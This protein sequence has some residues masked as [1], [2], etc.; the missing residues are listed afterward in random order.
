[1]R[2]AKGREHPIQLILL[3]SFKTIH[4][5][6]KSLH[7]LTFHTSRSSTFLPHPLSILQAYNNSAVDLFCLTVLIVVPWCIPFFIVF[8]MRTAE[9][10]EHPIQC[11]FSFSFKSIHSS[12]R[13]QELSTTS[14]VPHFFPVHSLT[15]NHTDVGSEFSF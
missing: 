4:P 5:F 6:L 15:Y 10:R 8:G 12:F 13:P 3:L 11:A 1:M 2:T 9:G 7:L 14:H